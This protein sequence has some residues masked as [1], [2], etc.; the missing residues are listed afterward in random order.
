MKHQKIYVLFFFWIIIFV[1]ICSLE[2]EMMRNRIKS[3]QIYNDYLSGKIKDR[4]PLLRIPKSKL[5]WQGWIKYFHYNLGE[6][7]DK[8]NAFFINQ[9]FF[10]QKILNFTLLI[11]VNFLQL[12]A[13]NQYFQ[14]F[15]HLLLMDNYQ[16]K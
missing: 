7:V 9:Q 14:N 11:L 15:H 10:N 5:Y 1:K 3:D 16:P 8:P 2:V 13:T 4:D 12:M 6:R